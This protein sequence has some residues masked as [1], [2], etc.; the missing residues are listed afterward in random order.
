MAIFRSVDL[1]QPEHLAVERTGAGRRAIG[2]VSVDER[3]PEIRYANAGGVHIAYQVD[4]TGPVDLVQVT[5]WAFN[6]EGIRQEP[7][8]EWASQR[9]GSFCRTI[10]FNR[11]GVGLSDPV[12]VAEFASLETW[13]DDVRAVMDAVGLERASVMG[14]GSGG[15]MAMLFAATHPDRVESLVLLNAFA[16]LSQAEDYP[17]GFPP[18]AQDGFLELIGASW[19]SGAVVDFIAPSQ[20]ADPD[21]VSWWARMERMSASPGTAMEVMKVMFELDLRHVLPA[22]T[23]PT[24]VIRTQRDWLDRGHST[25]LAS[26]IPGARFVETTGETLWLPPDAG[27]MFDAIEDFLTGDRADR[28]PDRV[29]ATV[30]FTDLTGS[31]ARASAMGDARWRDLLDQHDAVVRRQLSRH[32]GREIKRTGDGFLVTF[33][34][35]GRAVRC[36]VSI[37]DALRSLDLEMRASL[38]TGEIELRGEDIGGI[39]VHIAARLLGIAESGEVVASRTVRDL[40]AGSGLSFSDRGTH[41]LKGVEDEWT[42]YAVS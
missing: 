21:F 2:F 7:K 22:I 19:G 37:R 41:S 3:E 15:Q 13:V 6:L 25:Y 10:A 30:L 12:P 42:L 1:R 5:E 4:G 38:H 32:R 9:L 40:T 29:L 14:N 27:A 35:P 20:A 26:A 16:R 31:T 8:M 11:R 36:A 34:G 24:L 28:E 33:D 17:W 23:V 39:A 18:E